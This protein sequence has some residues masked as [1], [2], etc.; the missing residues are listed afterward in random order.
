M[1]LKIPAIKTSGDLAK[2]FEVSIRRLDWLADVRRQH[3]SADE[4]A[5][6]HYHITTIRKSSGRPRLLESPKSDLKRTQR[7]ILR[8]ILDCV[9]ASDRA[10]GFVKG[11]SCLSS[12]SIHAGEACVVAM[13]I[14]N[15][16]HAVTEHRVRLLFRRLGYPYRIADL[17]TRLCLTT[18][19]APVFAEI[20]GSEG[21]DWTERKLLSRQHL[22][23]G[24]PTSPALANLCAWGLDRRLAG[25]AARYD[26]NYTRYADDLAFS[27]D[28]GFARRI[29]TFQSAVAA[30]VRDEGFAIHPDKTRI[31]R[32]HTCQNLTGIV[33][34]AHVNIARAEY[35]RLKAI[36]HN[37]RRHGVS[38]QNREGHGDFRRHLDGRVNWVEN[39]NP[40]RGARLRT[41]F[42][43]IA[44]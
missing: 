3:A 1:D 44:W 28:A 25:L 4:P 24:A 14:R 36:L 20:S 10:H 38:G 8:E 17:L 5:L 2:W 6:R 11:R 23:Q 13:D 32:A 15:F 40:A 42:E 33:V 27:G 34:N 43:E 30:I 9:P 39:V 22:P 29:H 19:P 35:D 7:K 18:T 21:F 31:M 37:C 12:A 16:F 41:Q 26:A